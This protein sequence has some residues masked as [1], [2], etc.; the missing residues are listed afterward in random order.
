MIADWATDQW[1]PLKSSV[2]LLD[3]WRFSWTVVASRLGWLG[4]SSAELLLS[5]DSVWVNVLLH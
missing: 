4:V 3:G 5:D 1:V 2:V